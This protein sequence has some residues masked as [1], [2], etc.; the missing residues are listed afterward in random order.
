M[1]YD[2]TGNELKKFN[3]SDSAGVLFL[4]ALNIPVGIITGEK[5]EIVKARAE[6]LRIDELHQGVGNKVAL[7]TKLSEKFQ[8]SFDEMAYIGDDLN[9]MSLLQMVGTSGC[10]S[11][12]PGYVQKLVQIVTT[13]SG[14]EGAFREFVETMLINAGRFDEALAKVATLVAPKQQ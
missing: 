10:P 12:S 6:K 3:T 14:G 9:D 2:R 7:A 8:V 11:N 4:R 1:Y 5:T 13:K